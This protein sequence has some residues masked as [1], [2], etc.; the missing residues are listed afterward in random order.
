MPANDAYGQ[1]VQYPVLADPPN[2]ET[3]FQTVVNGLVALTVMRFDNANDRAATLVGASAPVRGMISYLIAEDRWDRFDGDGVWRAMSPG[4]WKPITFASGYTAF[5]GSPGYRIVNGEVQLRG[6][7]RRSSGG[8]LAVTTETTFLTLP[9]EARPPDGRVFIAAGNA[10]TSG[11]IT[12][13]SGR[14]SVQSSGVCSFFMPA[15]S[16]SEFLYLDQVRFS[17]D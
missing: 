9:T 17:I 10:T 4:Q 11:G 7:F 8:D 3:A 16:T 6:A 14:I 15:G 5:G 2:A 12:R 13:F 1:G